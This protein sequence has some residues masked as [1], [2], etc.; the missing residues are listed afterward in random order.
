MGADETSLI[1]RACSAAPNRVHVCLDAASNIVIMDANG[2]CECFDVRDGSPLGL[3]TT[4]V[5]L[6]PQVDWE[7]EPPQGKVFSNAW[8]VG[9][10]RWFGWVNEK[11]GGEKDGSAWLFEPNNCQ[12]IEL[13]RAHHHQVWFALGLSNGGFASLGMNS[14]TGALVVWESPHEPK[15]ITT[16]HRPGCK[17]AGIVELNDGSLLIWPFKDDGSAACLKS[18]EGTDKWW[19]IWSLQSTEEIVGAIS[20]PSSPHGWARFVTWTQTGEVRLW[21]TE[22][23]PKPALHRSSRPGEVIRSPHYL[24]RIA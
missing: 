19:K 9:K 15:I 16:P 23:A 3:F 24:S 6:L 11:E 21:T 12:W 2:A 8:P 14:N 10:G 1:I 13:P 5:A 20:V 18:I 4:P 17:G 22:S 7:Q